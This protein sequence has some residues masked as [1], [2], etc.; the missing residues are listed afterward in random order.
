L[1]AD[2]RARYIEIYVDVGNDQDKAGAREPTNRTRVDDRTRQD[3]DAGCRLRT[4]SQDRT[5]QRPYIIEV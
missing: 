2:S 4:E 5:E 3:Q 1:E